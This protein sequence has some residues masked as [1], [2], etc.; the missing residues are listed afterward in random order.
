VCRHGSSLLPPQLVSLGFHSCNSGLQV[1]APRRREDFSRTD[2]LPDSRWLQWVVRSRSHGV[3]SVM[4]DG[5][6]CCHQLDECRIG[7][8]SRVWLNGDVSGV[9]GRKHKRDWRLIHRRYSCCGLRP[10]T[11]ISLSLRI[12]AVISYINCKS[13]GFPA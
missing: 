6:G 12:S 10:K 13:C 9:A 3:P 2:Q 11:G 8:C 5:R 4:G 7:L 1:D